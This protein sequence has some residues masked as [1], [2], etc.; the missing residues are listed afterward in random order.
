[1][2]VERLGSFIEDLSASY[3]YLADLSP[4]AAERLLDEVERTVALI[5]RVPMIGRR[6]PE[7]SPGMR[8]FKI[9]RFRHLIFYRLEADQIVLVRLL[10]GSRDIRRRMFRRTSR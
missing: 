8:S 9:R 5:Q 2:R 4:A 6:R 1:M 10:H 3:G 7:L